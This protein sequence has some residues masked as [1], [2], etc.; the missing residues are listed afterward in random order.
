[1]ILFIS[2]KLILIEG[3]FN[4][5]HFGTSKNNQHFSLLY[6]FYLS[7]IPIN[8]S[9]QLYFSLFTLSHLILSLH[10]LLAT[11]HTIIAVHVW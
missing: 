6:F 7:L 11:K 8:Q 10:F 2:S 5:G 4:K 9:N 1:L 3:F